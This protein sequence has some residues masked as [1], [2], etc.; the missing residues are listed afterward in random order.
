MHE[1]QGQMGDCVDHGISKSSLPGCPI[2]SLWLL[3]R[4]EILLG[5]MHAQG[6]MGDCADHGIQIIAIGVSYGLIMDVYSVNIN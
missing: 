1:H 4:E 2:V 5:I 6:Q 3:G